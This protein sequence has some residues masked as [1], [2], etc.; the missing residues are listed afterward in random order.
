[1][2]FKSNP[3]FLKRWVKE[4]P[5]K[6]YTHNLFAELAEIVYKRSKYITGYNNFNTF[7]PDKQ[8]YKTYAVSQNLTWKLQT[9]ERSFEGMAVFETFNKRE[10]TQRIF[11][12]SVY[13]KY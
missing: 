4:K 1:L 13:R 2:S 9:D 10:G 11:T 12:N 3:H 5:F 7:I 6:T 8:T